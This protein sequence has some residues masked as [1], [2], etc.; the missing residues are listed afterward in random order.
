LDPIKISVE[1]EQHAKENKIKS[2]SLLSQLDSIK[3]SGDSAARKGK[4][5]QIGVGKTSAA[6]ER[7]S[8]LIDCQTWVRP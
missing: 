6:I 4:S 2:R 5:N 1:F 7:K 3:I 8:N